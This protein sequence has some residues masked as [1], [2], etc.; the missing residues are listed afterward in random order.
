MRSIR[1]AIPP[2]DRRR[3]AEA[4]AGQA[5]G[6]RAVRHARVVALFSSFG[7]EIATDQL[8]AGL[9]GA[10]KRVL[11][12]Y[13]DSGEM[14]VAE[15]D[16]NDPPVASA[17]GPEEPARRDPVRPEEIDAVI[18]PGLA[19]DRRG[20]RLGYGGGHYDR[21]LR[22]VRPA[23]VRVGIGFHAQLLEAVPHGPGDE[24]LDMV[25]TEREVVACARDADG[26]FGAAGR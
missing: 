5:L 6:L 16:P 18:V 17:Y 13:L 24:A 14:D 8:V 10:G 25:I 21:F 22:R 19:F 4:V 3:A 23:A 7:S 2:A 26:P 20:H 11:L 1:Q 15:V 9:M 12:P